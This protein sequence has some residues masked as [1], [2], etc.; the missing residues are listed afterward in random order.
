MR[1][2]NEQNPPYPYWPPEVWKRNSHSAH[3]RNF[4]RIDADFLGYGYL[5]KL[6]AQGPYA[7]EK[8]EKATKPVNTRGNLGSLEIIFEVG[9]S[10]PTPR[11]RRIGPHT[12][13]PPPHLSIAQVP[14]SRN[15]EE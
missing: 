5:F 12:H 6:S 1:F 10:L 9:L 7:W 15:S 2:G 13:A 8:H 3:V 14:S 4:S 11:I